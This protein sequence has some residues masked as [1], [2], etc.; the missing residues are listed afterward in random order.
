MI[1]EGLYRLIHEG[2]DLADATQEYWRGVLGRRRADRRH[3]GTAAARTKS[4]PDRVCADVAHRRAKAVNV[5]SA[6]ACVSFV[7]AWRADLD[8]WRGRADWI[9]PWSAT[10]R[11]RRSSS[12][13]RRRRGA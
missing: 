12:T 3:S 5:M 7:R 9:F 1:A 11:A 2:A 13:S 4:A 10:W 6:L 8:A